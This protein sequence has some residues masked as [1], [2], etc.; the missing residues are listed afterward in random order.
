MPQIEI[1]TGIIS[2]KWMDE[3]NSQDQDSIRRH[4]H[5]SSCPY[6][7]FSDWLSVR[8]INQSEDSAAANQ[9]A[10]IFH[11]PMKNFFLWKKLLV[12]LLSNYL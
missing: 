9:I 5:R 2:T 12:M 3:I 6:C 11:C 1:K 4:H 10:E 8:A 7:L